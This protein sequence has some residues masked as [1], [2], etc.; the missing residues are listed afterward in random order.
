MEK[1]KDYTLI[2][3][4]PTL[5]KPTDSESIYYGYKGKGWPKMIYPWRPQNILKMVI[6][7]ITSPDLERSKDPS[8]SEHFIR[9]SENA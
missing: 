6:V 4:G 8:F 3:T 1:I 5:G 2:L 9:R 7:L